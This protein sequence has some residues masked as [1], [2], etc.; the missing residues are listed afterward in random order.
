MF[1]EYARLLF[2]FIRGTS[3]N[4]VR[5]GWAPTLTWL[6]WGPK[7]QQHR[8]IL[9]PA[10]SKAH[11]AQYQ[12]HQKKQAALCMRNILDDAVNWQRATRQFAVAVM[13]N[14]A[15]GID[16]DGP[17]S[18]WIKIAEDSAAAVGNSGAPASSIIDRFPASMCY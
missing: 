16:I 15:Y 4:T 18:P 6:R 17:R 5:M 10:F 3:A 8:R 14:I 2:T 9:Q 13:L 12:E 11:V 1:E 7:M